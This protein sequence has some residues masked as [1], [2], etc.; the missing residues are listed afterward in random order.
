MAG[1][2]KCTE[3]LGGN[4]QSARSRIFGDFKKYIA[5]AERQS[6]FSGFS[7]LSPQR[8]VDL[9]TFQGDFLK[10]LNLRFWLFPGGPNFQTALILKMYQPTRFQRL[11]H[12]KLA[13]LES[14]KSV[15]PRVSEYRSSQDFDFFHVN[16]L[17]V[18]PFAIP[19]KGRF[20]F[21]NGTSALTT[22][23]QSV[24]PKSGRVCTISKNRH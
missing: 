14:Q 22:P 2:R 6:G 12:P 9:T 21:K 24:T 23:G 3:R 4:D 20:F 16:F 1:F 10:K 7:F 8:S 17:W 11:R 15:S 13:C 18:L 19:L 5:P